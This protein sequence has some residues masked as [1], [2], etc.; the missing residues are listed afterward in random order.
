MNEQRND[1]REAKQTL[2]Q[3]IN[4]MDQEVKRSFQSYI[5]EVQDYFTTV[6]Q[7]LFGGGHAK[8]ELTDDDYLSAGVDIIVQPPGKNYKIFLY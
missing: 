7:S 1:L 8:L 5:F 3:I 2:E 6:F 4:E